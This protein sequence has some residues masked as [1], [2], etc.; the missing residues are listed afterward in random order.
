MRSVPVPVLSVMMASACLLLAACGFQPLYGGAGAATLD[1]VSVSVT[2]NE[3]RSYLTETALMERV[4]VSGDRAGTLRVTV[5]T[6]P[7]PLG[8]SADGQASRVALNV[9]AHYQLDDGTGAVLASSVVER[10]VFETPQ[11]PYALITARANAEQRAAEALADALVRDALIGLRQRET[12]RTRPDVRPAGG[13]E[14]S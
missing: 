5:S 4:G 3:R 12:A 9:R 8:V 1:N 7:T 2:G 11:E 6:S 14:G 10:I 13:P